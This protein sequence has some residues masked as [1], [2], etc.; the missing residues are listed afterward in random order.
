MQYSTLSATRYQHSHQET[1]DSVLDGLPCQ[2]T[3]HG[4][5][6]AWMVSSWQLDAIRDTTTAVIHPEVFSAS[7]LTARWLEV[8][9]CL[10]EVDIVRAYK[11]TRR[12]SFAV[13]SPRFFFRIRFSLPPAPPVLPQLTATLSQLNNSPSRFFRSAARGT[14]VRIT[15]HGRPA[16]YLLPATRLAKS[17]LNRRNPVPSSLLCKQVGLVL[18]L[19]EAGQGDLQPV[20]ITRKELLA[21]VPMRVWRRL[22]GG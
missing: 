4:E 3:H 13:V 1:H 10:A 6:V 5:T 17:E 9:A 22:G 7:Q 8:K 16:G 15:E 12:S 19:M 2:L 18:D 11:T 14:V 21:L 20:T